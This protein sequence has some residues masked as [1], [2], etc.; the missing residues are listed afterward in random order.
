MSGMPSP[1]TPLSDLARSVQAEW[2]TDTAKETREL[3]LAEDHLATSRIGALPR[4]FDFLDC[5][6]RR[7]AEGQPLYTDDIFVP[8][9]NE[10]MQLVDK[11][12]PVLRENLRSEDILLCPLTI[13]N[14]PDHHLVR[15]AAERTGHPLHYYADIPYAL[16]HSEQL[17]DITENLSARVFPITEEEMHAWQ[18]AAAAYRTQNIVLFGGEE[19]M[20]N[21][22]KQYWRE[23]QS[24]Q[25]YL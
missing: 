21:A 15:L 2:G 22:I 4:Y 7:N 17:N 5:I 18:H 9:P 20:K 10:D 24:I 23:T 19:K 1:N 25:L 16:E 8:M 6:Y 13:G 14:H 12:A 11:I 3:R